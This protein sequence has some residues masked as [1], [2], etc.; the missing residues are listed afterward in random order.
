MTIQRRAPPAWR[1]QMPIKLPLASL[2]TGPL[3]FLALL[4]SVG[5]IAFMLYFRRLEQ[6]LPPSSPSIIQYEFA[7]TP[8]R[9]IKMF[10][11]W[12]LAGQ[13]VIRWSLYIDF[14]FMPVY[15]FAFAAV[16]LLA[17]RAAVGRA[18]TWGVRLLWA[19]FVAW[20]FDILENIGLLVALG[21]P[22]RPSGLA[23]AVSA[24]SASLK[25]ASLGLSLVYW[26]GVVAQ[27]LATRCQ[28]P[29]IAEERTHGN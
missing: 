7:A 15:A 17:A 13:A 11:V 25:F 14:A 4:F 22:E 6:Q 19:P 12:Q 24:G 29:S 21:R 5:V 18:Q 10:N 28:R 16:T 27:R 2:Q 3:A 20:A 26:F 9:A 8:P 1:K 23:L